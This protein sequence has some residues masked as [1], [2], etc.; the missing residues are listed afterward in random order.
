MNFGEKLRYLRQKERKTLEEQGGLFGVKLNT[1]F[2]WEH[3]Q[4]RPN[5]PT[6]EKI[7]EYYDVSTSWL[8]QES[9]DYNIE[10][11]NTAASSTSEV[12][13]RIIRIL[14]KLPENEK[15]KILGYVERAYTETY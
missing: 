8:L 6:L 11:L 2:R 12:E 15:Y 14:S 3:N 4:T 1:V 7:A 9:N 13:Q 5:R 10:G